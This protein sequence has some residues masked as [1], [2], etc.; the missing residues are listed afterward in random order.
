MEYSEQ[1]EAIIAFSL[2][3]KKNGKSHVLPSGL[4]DISS[5]RLTTQ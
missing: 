3:F 1:C 2:V 4:A 5:S